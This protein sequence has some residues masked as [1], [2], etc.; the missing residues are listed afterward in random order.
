MVATYKT[1]GVTETVLGTITG[2]RVQQ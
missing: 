1:D 2:T